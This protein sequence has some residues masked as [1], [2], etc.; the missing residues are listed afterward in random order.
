[1]RP[2]LLTLTA[3]ALT[4]ATAAAQPA[5]PPAALPPV[6]PP[7]VAADPYPTGTVFA[8]DVLTEPAYDSGAGRTFWA[9]VEYLYWWITPMNTPGLIQAIPTPVAQPGLIL[10]AGSGTPLFPKN[11]QLQFPG[12]NG[13]RITAGSYF[14]R[15]SDWGFDVGYYQLETETVKVGAY[16]NGVPAAVGATFVDAT[17]GLPNV[18][19]YSLAGQYVGGLTAI[20]DTLTWG[21]EAN[22]RYR[23]SA[24]F[25]DR[26]DLTNGFRYHDLQE[27]LGLSGTSIDANGSRLDTLDV[28]RTH[29]QFY[30][31]QFGLASRFGACQKGLGLDTAF[32]FGFGGVRQQAV[33]FGSNTIANP[34]QAPTTEAAGLY[35][36]P[37]NIGN[38]ARDEFAAMTDLKLNLTYNFNPRAQVFFGYSLFW[39]SS[40]AR[41]GEIINP[42]INAS[43]VRFLQGTTPSPVVAPVFRWNTND[44]WVQGLNFGAQLA[45]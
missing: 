16:T 23:V 10:P 20:A 39:L 26:T 43:Q 27:S 33:L 32:K 44:Y 3:L 7:P 36:R 13:V 34:G 17:T 11:R 25:A 24:L 29:N 41:P 38:F 6:G 31:Y 40:V 21:A 30:G 37:A 12:M 42:V 19:F 14:A 1:M 15:N 2:A 35:V 8:T 22:L 18:L 5:Y 45:Y 28:V 9:S 4:A